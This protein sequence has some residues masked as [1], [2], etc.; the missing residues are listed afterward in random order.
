MSVAL[1]M[2]HMEHMELHMEHMEHMELH[3]EH[4]EHMEL[5]MKHM[6]Q[7][8]LHMEHME[9]HSSIPAANP[10]TS[11]SSNRWHHILGQAHPCTAQICAP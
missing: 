7:M 1:H 8:E 6:E 11:T 2:E 4:M 5:H 10:W 9:L 3:M